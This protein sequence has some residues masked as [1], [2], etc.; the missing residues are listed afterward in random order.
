MSG[1]D[2]NRAALTRKNYLLS[3]EEVETILHALDFHSY[4]MNLSDPRL[5]KA[6][7]AKERLS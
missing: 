2:A 5:E 3:A 6:R 4:A 7:A 1:H